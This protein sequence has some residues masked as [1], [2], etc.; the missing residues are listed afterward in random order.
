MNQQHITIATVALKDFVF[1]LATHGRP[2]QGGLP[3]G[4]AMY[5]SHVT[6][7]SSGAGNEGLLW[8][9]QIENHT[10]VL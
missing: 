7:V 5:S 8:N 6:L 10:H 1:P 3:A 2:K 9:C 4:S